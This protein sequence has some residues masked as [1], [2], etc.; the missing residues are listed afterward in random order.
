M[1]EIVFNGKKSYSMDK[2]VFNGQNCV[3]LEK[4]KRKKVGGW[5]GGAK[6]EWM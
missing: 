5:G 1:D 2:M 4:K 3:E 6:R